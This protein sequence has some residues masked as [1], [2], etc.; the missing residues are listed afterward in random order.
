MSEVR[1]IGK[2]LD[3]IPFVERPDG[4]TSPVWRYEG[5]PIVDRNP[6]KDVARI[7]NSAVLPYQGEFIG[8]FRAEE[9]T[10]KAYLRLGRSK[11]GINF[12]FEDKPIDFFNE[13]G[14]PCI[15]AVMIDP[16]LVEIEGIYYIVWCEGMGRYPAI[17]IAETKDFKTFIKKPY[18]LLPPNRNGVLFPKKIGGE[19]IL[20]SRPS[21]TG[22]TPFGDI[23]MSRSTDMR[24]WGKHELVMPVNEDAWWQ[25]LKIG[26]GA[27]PIETSE[28]WL[29]FYHGVI[30]TCS[31]YVYSMGGALLDIDNPAVVKYNCIRYLLTPEKSY[32]TSGFVP[33]VIFPCAALADSNTGRI[34]IYY[35]GADTVTALAFTTADI[36]VD[37]IKKNVK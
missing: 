22:H 27:V 11:D 5:N 30:R 18:P 35:G 8:I 28:G 25:I 14:T 3:N 31:G 24:Y 26:P 19:Y 12:K 36:I 1:I 33:N 34:A 37:F 7:F 32:E 21:D 4:D 23:F 29:I 13:D 6:M 9:T 17:G 20:L 2:K 10:I 16:R 15:P